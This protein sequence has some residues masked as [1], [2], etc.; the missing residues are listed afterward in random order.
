VQYLGLGLT[1][2]LQILGNGHFPQVGK[3]THGSVLLL[4]STHGNATRW[5]FDKLS[6]FSNFCVSPIGF[7]IR[8][9]DT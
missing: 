1:H 7:L 3:P 6:F 4:V 8:A 5:Q 9:G 2:I